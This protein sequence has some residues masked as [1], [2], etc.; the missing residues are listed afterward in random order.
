MAFRNL[1][2]AE[3][4]GIMGA[5]SE[6]SNPVEK[7]KTGRLAILDQ[8]RPP[9]PTQPPVSLRRAG[10][11]SI[12]W[13]LPRTF[14]GYTAVVDTGIGGKATKWV[15]RHNERP[16]D[17]YIAKFGNKNGKTEVY[18]ELFNNQLGTALGFDVAHSGIARLDENI[19][20]ITRNF[21]G[22]NERLVHGSLMIEEIFAAPK[23][24]EQI[25]HHEE[26][27]FYTIDV[28]RQVIDA[29][30]G[31]NSAAVFIAFVE[32]LVFDALIGSMDRHAQN[33]GV[34][35]TTTTPKRF[36][37]APIFD[38]ARALFW[39]IPD[40][41]LPR[42]HYDE[43]AFG[44]DEQ[45]SFKA[46]QMFTRYVDSSKPCIG[47]EPKH[48]KINDCNHFD[49]ISS[50][51]RLYP[52]QTKEALRKIPSDPALEAAKIL[53]SFPFENAFWSVRKHLILRVLA[54]RAVRLRQIL[55]TG[56]KRVSDPR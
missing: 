4:A 47:P 31:E 23:A 44:K 7:E 5:V 11:G 45:A 21:R 54:V 24:T 22:A 6:L 52:H 13:G 35:Q 18:T 2:I 20:F 19:Y 49:L 42:F 27:S 29:F 17:F 28:I 12:T 26:Q 46:D 53:H 38:S 36:R 32:M 25:A 39:D 56:E 33:W 51:L 48:P 34:L 9:I 41:R 14:S 55:E 37:L 10:S 1:S 50:L 16:I 40:G 43:N 8:E 3:T 30:C 15:L